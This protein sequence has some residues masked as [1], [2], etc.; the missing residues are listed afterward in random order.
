MSRGFCQATGASRYDVLIDSPRLSM[1]YPRYLTSRCLTLV[2]AL[3]G[4]NATVLA[5]TPE[6][7]IESVFAGTP[8]DKW[9]TEGPHQQVPWEVRMSARMLSIHQRLI[10]RVEV[11]VSGPELVRRC[12]DD[13]ITLLLQVTDHAGATYRTYGVLELSNMKPEMNKSDIVF[14]WD[15]FALPGDYTVDVALY[16]KASGEHN[17]LHGK[18]RVDSLKNDPLKND[19]VQDVWQGLP[20]FEFWS[21]TREGLDFLFH[22][23]I[24]GRLHLPLQTK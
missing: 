20:S 18:L 22:S 8:F 3:L 12:A 19:T 4:L 15:A 1:A 14:S 23:D 16:D 10:A 2:L 24:E 21:P 11:Q 13:H 7:S 17:F 5:Q 6:P 9:L